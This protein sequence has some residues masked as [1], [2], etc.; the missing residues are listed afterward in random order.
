[1]GETFLNCVK[2][3]LLALIIL[4]FGT[5]VLLPDKVAERVDEI[6]VSFEDKGIEF[7]VQSGKLILGRTKAE[8]RAAF[9]AEEVLDAIRVK[10]TCLTSFKCDEDRRKPC[11]S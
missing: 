1:M 10:G 11:P 3:A 4:F 7:S 8:V 6:L 9:E 5:V 2:G